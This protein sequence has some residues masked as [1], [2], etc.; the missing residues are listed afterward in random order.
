MSRSSS[1]ASTASGVP[2][3]GGGAAAST[4]GPRTTF[5]AGGSPADT[6]GTKTAITAITAQN[7]LGISSTFA[8]SADV[9]VAQIEAIASDVCLDATK[10]GMLATAAIVEAVAAAVRGYR[11]LPPGNTNIIILVL[12]FRLTKPK[13]WS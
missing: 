7:T 10:I 8:L 9:V 2:T 13:L 3:A 4:T 6:T 11:L 1:A 5:S 12:S